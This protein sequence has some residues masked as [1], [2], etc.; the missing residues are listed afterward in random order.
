MSGLTTG[1]KKK[2]KKEKLF[3]AGSIYCNILGQK[4]LGRLSDQKTHFVPLKKNRCSHT[5]GK[6]KIKHY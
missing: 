3:L 5:R 1:K 4:K 6:K 2:R